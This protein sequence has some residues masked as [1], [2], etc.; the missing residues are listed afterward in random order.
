[1]RQRLQKIGCSTCVLTHVFHI[2]LFNGLV[3]S[4]HLFDSLIACIGIGP[5]LTR[6][7]VLVVRRKAFQHY[8]Q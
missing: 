8:A 1:M 4:R 3:R 2:L 7:R 5:E 6:R